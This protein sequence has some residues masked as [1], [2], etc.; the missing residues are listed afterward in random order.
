MFE[1]TRSGIREMKRA[2]ESICGYWPDVLRSFIAKIEADI[3]AYDA[4]PGELQQIR[5]ALN[6][7]DNASDGECFHFSTYGDGSGS[8]EDT[9]GEEVADAEGDLASIL[10]A[11]EAAMPKPGPSIEELEKAHEQTVQKCDEAY[12]EWLEA[13]RVSTLAY[14]KLVVARKGTEQ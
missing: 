7:L 2:V 5:A 13:G 8:I 1:K 6:D 9:S 10:A 4:A 3:A 12:R 11:I 14:N